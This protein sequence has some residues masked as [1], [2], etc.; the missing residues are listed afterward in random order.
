MSPRV[1][2]AQGH[3]SAKTAGDWVGGVISRESDPE[4]DDLY[5][6][7][8]HPDHWRQPRKRTLSNGV[9]QIVVQCRRCGRQVDHVR[10][11]ETALREQAERNPPFDPEISERLLA[12]ER[13]ESETR[14]EREQTAWWGRYSAYMAS[15]TWW[16]KRCERLELDAYQCQARLANC[17]RHAE[18]VHHLTY[19]HLGNEPLFELISVCTAC[20]DAI[21]AMDRQRRGAS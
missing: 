11:H 6:R 19:V 2:T 12:Q 16:S 10:K 14:R 9:I 18:Q 17:T 3:H 8:K 20:H 1:L 7:C 21:T 4:A 5:W 13:A 15:D